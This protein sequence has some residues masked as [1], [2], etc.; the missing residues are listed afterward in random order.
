[1]TFLRWNYKEHFKKDLRYYLGV[2]VARF[3]EDENAFVIAEMQKNN[4]LKIVAVEV[5]ENKNLMDTCGRILALDEL[6]HFRK[7][8]IDDAGLG[9]GLTD[10]LME[11][12]GRRIVGLNNAKKRIQVEG[13]EKKTGILKEDLYSNAMVLMESEPTKIDIINDPMLLRSLRSMTYEYTS[14]KNLR[15]YGRNSHR[16][17]AFVRA[18]WSI[19]EKGLRIYCY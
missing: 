12:I 16:A 10:R 6:Y 1:M 3:G 2:D 14:D 15:I 19:K 18:C 9:A 11:K 4:N 5:S 13:E 8:L 17:E 7:I